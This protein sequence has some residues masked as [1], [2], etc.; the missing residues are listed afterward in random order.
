MG[1][2]RFRHSIADWC[3][4]Y[5]GPKLGTPQICDLATKLNVGI[6][7]PAQSEWAEIRRRN[8]SIPCVL[9]DMPPHKPYAQGFSNPA[10]WDA[11]EA[12]LV[13]TI[14]AAADHCIPN[15]LVFTGYQDPGIERS[16]AMTNCMNG[17]S[18]KTLALAEKCGVT[19]LLEFLN[20][21]GVDAEMTGHPGYCGDNL[22][23]VVDIVKRI[24]SPWFK[25]ALDLYHV[26][27]AGG[28]AANAIAAHSAVTGYI[29]TAGV[30]DTDTRCELH[31]DGQKI[32]YAGAAKMLHMTGYQRWMCHEFLLRE[33]D[34]EESFRRAIEICES[35]AVEP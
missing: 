22:L 16:A 30:R 32:P 2:R 28:S 26:V 33:P 27:M 6:D 35:G 5:T 3:V 8:I 24:N 12:A 13:E 29:H 1:T 4:R 21:T 9:A 20:V 23:E 25:L 19:L 18:R 11:V 31:A 15:V 10:Q 17:F 7:L 14:Q 34:Y